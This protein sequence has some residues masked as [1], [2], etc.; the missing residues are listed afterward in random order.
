MMHHANTIWVVTGW[1][2]QGQFV[3]GHIHGEKN[4]QDDKQAFRFAEERMRIRCVRLFH[5]FL[6][7]NPQKTV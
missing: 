3:T 5:R 1:N 7:E 4:V 2:D 6:S